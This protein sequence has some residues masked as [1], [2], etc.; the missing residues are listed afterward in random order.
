MTVNQFR[1]WL[2]NAKR[3]E[4]L[5]YFTGFSGQLGEKADDLR[6]AVSRAYIAD[7]CSLVQKKTGVK[8]QKFGD[9]E[10]EF[11]AIKR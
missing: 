2:F 5:V 9:N 4:K 6:R 1:R 10:Y 7:E 11:I 3:G 8:C